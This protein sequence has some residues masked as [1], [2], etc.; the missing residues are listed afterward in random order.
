MRREIIG[1]IILAV[2]LA[3][4]VSVLAPNIHW[5]GAVFRQVHVVVQRYD[6]SPV[7]GAR[8]TFRDNEYDRVMKKTNAVAHMTQAELQ[9][10]QSEH[11]ASGMADAN[12][13]FAFR[14]AFPAGG[15]RV[16]FWDNGRF[17]LRGTVIVEADGHKTIERPLWQLAGKKSVSVRRYRRKPIVI[18]CKLER[19]H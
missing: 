18:Q 13:S 17:A 1:I 10:R 14:A 6:G 16:L 19:E 3:G 7:S 5:D 9:K 4:A 15:T 8:V 11:Y 2:V 12:G